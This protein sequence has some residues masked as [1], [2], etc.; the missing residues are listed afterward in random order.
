MIEVFRSNRIDLDVL[1]DLTRSEMMELGISA[2]GD[3]KCLEKTR[4]RFNTG[5]CLNTASA[6]VVIQLLTQG[7]T[8]VCSLPLNSEIESGQELLYDYRE[9]S[10]ATVQNFSW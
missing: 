2:L 9:R 7:H 3:I 5:V 8:Y 10:K 6:V 4:D 1:K